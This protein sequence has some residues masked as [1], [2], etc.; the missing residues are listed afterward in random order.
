[1]NEFILTYILVPQVHAQSSIHSLVGKVNEFVINPLIALLFAL[2]FVLFVTGL[3]NFFGNREN[4][5]ALEKGKR[6][7]VWGIVGMVVMVSVFGIM[8]LII[9]TLDVRGINSPEDGRVTNLSR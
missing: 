7:M 6:H 2:A 8:R 1:M 5:E 9:S 4:G 3:F